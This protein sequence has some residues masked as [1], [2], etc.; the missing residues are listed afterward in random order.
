MFATGGS[1]IV[2]QKMGKEKDEEI[3]LY[4]LFIVLM[5]V[6]TFGDNWCAGIY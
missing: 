3:K 6:G 2:A 1:A 4:L 5:A